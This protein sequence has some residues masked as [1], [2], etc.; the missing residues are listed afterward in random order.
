MIVKGS[1]VT[2]HYTLT[3][4][5]EEIDTSRG[6]EP[7]SY[8]HG[9][10]Q[11]IPGLEE[12]LEGKAVG[13]HDTVEISPDKGYGVHDP[14]S[15]QVIPKDA[16]ADV[17]KLEEGMEVSGEDQDGERFEATVAEVGEDD[18]TLDFNHPLAGKTLTFDI[19]IV[20]IS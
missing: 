8:E 18:I 6:G 5:G 1:Q 2:L 4:D 19:E 17:D 20:T 11:L 9:A 3:V 14:E 16:F 12:Y 7:L 15:V 10:G 13:H